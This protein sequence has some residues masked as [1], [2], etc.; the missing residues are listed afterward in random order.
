MAIAVI[1]IQMP[2]LASTF[3]EEPPLRIGPKETDAITNQCLKHLWAVSKRLQEGLPPGKDMI[4]PASGKP[5][6]VIRDDS[7]IVVRSPSPELYGFNELRVSN[8]NPV[9]ELIP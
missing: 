4:C 6:E 1:I 7:N 2:K 8:Q 9:P 5:F 3:K